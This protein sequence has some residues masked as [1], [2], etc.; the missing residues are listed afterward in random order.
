MTALALVVIVAQTAVSTAQ[1]ANR[2]FCEQSTI[3]HAWGFVY[4]GLYMES[5]GAVYR[6]DYAGSSER[7]QPAVTA[8]ALDRRFAPG[9][10]HIGAV[11]S[12]TIASLGALLDSVQHGT[13]G[14][15]VHR[16]YDGG[17]AVLTCYRLNAD[18]G[19]YEQVVLRARG[20]WHRENESPAARRLAQRLDSVF[21]AMRPRTPSLDPER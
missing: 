6:F 1:S 7:P 20:D 3:N 2:F 21:A 5:R 16:G 18:R 10:E 14:Q 19:L 9:R 13:L 15:R 17:A 4:R 8:P 12:V 11:D